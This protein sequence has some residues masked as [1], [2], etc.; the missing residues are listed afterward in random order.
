ML[1]QP[2][3]DCAEPPLAVDWTLANTN[4]QLVRACRFQAGTQ[5]NP[6]RICHFG[7]RR[8]LTLPNPAKLKGKHRLQYNMAKSRSRGT[9]RRENASKP[10]VASK[11]F[12]VLRTAGTHNPTANFRP[13]LT[14]LEM[15]SIQSLY[16]RLFE[17][18][19][20]AKLGAD[21]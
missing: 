14:M 11:V 20:A 6:W 17:S 13:P 5:A 15:D 19:M 10:S 3:E 8:S 4:H 2:A 1:F 7:Q 18:L 9:E 16:H 21:G 12:R